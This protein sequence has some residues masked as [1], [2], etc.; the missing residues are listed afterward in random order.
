MTVYA[1]IL[2]LLNSAVNYLLLLASARLGG[3]AI[4]RARLLLAAG[5]G[6]IYG[7]LALLPALGFL[8][9]WPMRLTMLVMMLLCAFGAKRQTLRLGLLF[10]G[11]SC[12]FAGLVLAAVQLLGSG[13]VLLPSGAYYPVSLAALLFLAALAYLVCDLVFSCL[14]LHGKQEITSLTLTLDKRSAPIRALCDTGNT[15]RDPITN[16]RVLIVGWDAAAQLLPEAAL[17]SRRTQPPDELLSLLARQ[18]PALR[19]RLIPY[20]AV[21]VSAGL[22]IAVRCTAQKPH[23]R[24][25]SVLA[26]FSPTPV[27]D[28]GNYNALT[29]GVL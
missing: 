21:G 13:L 10:L 23:G 26:A 5:F 25:F 18:Y 16:E 15:L 8:Q 4:H 24:P 29:G 27:S 28:G 9:T 11:T 20:R 22:L 6:S 3:G 17:P 1:D 7:V 2:F 12:C 14:C 19:F